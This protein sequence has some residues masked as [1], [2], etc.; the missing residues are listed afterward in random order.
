MRLGGCLLS[1]KEDFEKLLD[2][3]D[4]AFLEVELRSWCVLK[5]EWGGRRSGERFHIVFE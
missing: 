4:E 3:D 1:S 5:L 2:G